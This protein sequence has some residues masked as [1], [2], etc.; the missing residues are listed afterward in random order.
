[1]GSP[2]VP[3]R[4]GS[5]LAVGA[6][7]V[8]G[9]ATRT[10]SHPFAPP[11]PEFT[12]GEPEPGRRTTLPPWPVGL[13]PLPRLS[14]PRRRLVEGPKPCP[15]PRTDGGGLTDWPP[16]SPVRGPRYAQSI[17]R[18]FPVR[19]NPACRTKGAFLHCTFTSM[20]QSWCIV[21]LVVN[22]TCAHERRRLHLVWPALLPAVT[23]LALVPVVSAS[24]ALAD[25]RVA[26]SATRRTTR[27][28]CR[29][30]CVQR[31]W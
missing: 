31:A 25:G 18:P 11:T 19:K 23:L 26:S 4:R 13:N 15:A 10:P 29:P 5:D 1:M 9:C 24:V 27:P 8:S 14:W 22:S 21:N 30:R 28:P 16:Q 7:S 2:G 12:P 20:S 3:L 17:D 6:P